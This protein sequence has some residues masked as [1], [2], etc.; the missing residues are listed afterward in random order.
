MLKKPELTE[1]KR[2]EYVDT[3]TNAAK[4]LNALITNILRLNKL[5]K[6]SISPHVSEF[7]LCEQLVQS[8]FLFEPVWEEKGIGQRLRYG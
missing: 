4:R 2:Q 3:I 1:E 6:Q 7:D 8:A 5:E